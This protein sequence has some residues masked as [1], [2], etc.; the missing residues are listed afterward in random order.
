VERHEVLR[1]VFKEVGG[2]AIRDPR[3]DEKFALREVDLS[4]EE[5]KERKR[6]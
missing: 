6:G 3:R 2:D 5:E 4:D 1:T